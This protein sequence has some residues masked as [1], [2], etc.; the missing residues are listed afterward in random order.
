MRTVLPAGA[1]IPAEAAEAGAW[2]KYTSEGS[3]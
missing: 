2:E 1:G 3:S